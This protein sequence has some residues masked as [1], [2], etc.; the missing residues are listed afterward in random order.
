MLDAPLRRLIDPKLNFFGEK[1]V[2]FG[3]S[4]DQITI[5]GFLIGLISLP[6]IANEVYGWALVTILINRLC[7]GLDG[8]VARQTKETDRGGFLDIILDFIFY[9][10]VIFAFGLANPENLLAASFLL[11]AYIGT[12]ASFLTYS[13]MVEKRGSSKVQ[14]KS[15]YYLGGLTEA[16]ETLALML[17]ICLLPNLF[18]IFAWI[19]GIMCWIT[20]ATR[21]LAGWRTFR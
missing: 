18:S 11:F 16:T 14:H 3:V 15:F 17:V 12:G 7:D 1:F 4:A 2:R 9:A 8:A 19:F 13:I 6:L 10:S 20:T 5:T 21:I